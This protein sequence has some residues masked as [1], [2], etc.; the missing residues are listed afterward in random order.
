[1]KHLHRAEHPYRDTLKDIFDR[2]EGSN[3]RM[4]MWQLG[5]EDTLSF[6]ATDI[7]GDPKHNV[8]FTLDEYSP[9][10]ALQLRFGMTDTDDACSR[11]GPH[12]A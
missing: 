9:E 6:E 2:E 7:G 4:S 8:Y 3:Q 11:R 10:Q 12:P 5:D 1:M